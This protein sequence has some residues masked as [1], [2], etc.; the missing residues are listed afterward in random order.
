MIKDPYMNI[1]IYFHFYVKQ[2][3]LH[4]RRL[5]N[6]F[7]DVNNLVIKSLKVN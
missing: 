7:Q 4:M 5:F 2:I 3:E 6:E 1:N